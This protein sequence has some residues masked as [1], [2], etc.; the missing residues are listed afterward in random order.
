ME[1]RKIELTIK[2]AIEWWLGD[3][4]TLRQLALSTY[5]EEELKD[6]FYSSIGIKSDTITV[7]MLTFSSFSRLKAIADYF[8]KGW[9][10]TLGT[11]GYFICKANPT[12]YTCKATC[13][14]YCI[15]SHESVKYPCT[16]YF[17]TIES[18]KKAIKIMGDSL[19][20]LFDE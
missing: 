18:A 4:E 11:K 12:S 3:N 8:N 9:I 16:V 15:L 7:D 20:Y 13:G 2:Q 6:E 19:D 5:T 1:T 10:K 14:N 17:K